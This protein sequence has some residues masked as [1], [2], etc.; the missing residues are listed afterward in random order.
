MPYDE[1]NKIIHTKAIGVTKKEL[2]DKQSAVQVIL[3][4]MFDAPELIDFIYL[5][6]MAIKVQFDGR[7]FE[8]GTVKS[9]YEHILLK[10]PSHVKSWKITGGYPVPLN[11]GHS[12]KVLGHETNNNREFKGYYGINLSIQ[13]L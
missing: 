9:K 2:N 7:E 6:G 8:L 1:V 4:H 5:F 10:N 11:A 3:K 12:V 13:V